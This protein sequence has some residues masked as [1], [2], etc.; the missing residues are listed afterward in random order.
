LRR[1][2]QDVGGLALPLRR[3]VF[4]SFRGRAGR[5]RGACGPALFRGAGERRQRGSARQPGAIARSRAALHGRSQAGLLARSGR[6]HG[7][8]GRGASGLRLFPD[9]PPHPVRRR[10]SEVLRR[11]MV[12]RRPQSQLGQQ[13]FRKSNGGIA[14]STTIFRNDGDGDGGVGPRL[15]TR[16]STLTPEG[17]PRF[18]I[19]RGGMKPLF[20]VNRKPRCR[21]SAS[22]QA[23]RPLRPLSSLQEK[24]NVSCANFGR[25]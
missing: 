24:N 17:P 6:V 14:A 16:R 21:E 20:P 19:C 11:P 23:K 13:Q 7:V 9:R 22:G 8:Q 15:R 25:P 3:R 18:P 4:P 1:R 12:S 2:G 5:R 10:K